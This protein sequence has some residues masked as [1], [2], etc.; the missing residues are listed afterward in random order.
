MGRGDSS[1]LCMSTDDGACTG[2]PT[3]PV[4]QHQDAEG[5]ASVAFR[6]TNKI[7]APA[8]VGQQDVAGTWT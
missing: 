8:G 1:D 2:R 5:A 4:P 6:R 3:G 7:V